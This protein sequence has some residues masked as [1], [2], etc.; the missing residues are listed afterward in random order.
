MIIVVGIRRDCP[1][2]LNAAV[3]DAEARS[4]LTVKVVEGVVRCNN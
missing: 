3:G 1:I 4:K 2:V